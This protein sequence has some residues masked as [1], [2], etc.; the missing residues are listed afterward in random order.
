MYSCGQTNS[1]CIIEG[2][3]LTQVQTHAMETLRPINLAGCI[4]EGGLLTQVQT[5]A[6]ETLRPAVL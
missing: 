5:H 4:I 2:G 1:G 3:L 6:I